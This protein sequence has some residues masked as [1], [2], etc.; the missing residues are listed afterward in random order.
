MLKYI[1][2]LVSLIFIGTLIKADDDAAMHEC[3]KK[4]SFDTCFYTLH[5]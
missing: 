4:Y 3:Q 1:L 2:I 5:H